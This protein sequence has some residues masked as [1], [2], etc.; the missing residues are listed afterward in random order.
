MEKFG[1]SVCLFLSRALANLIGRRSAIQKK[2]KKMSQPKQL[3]I[4]KYRQF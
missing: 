3:S 2:K 4:R 1:L